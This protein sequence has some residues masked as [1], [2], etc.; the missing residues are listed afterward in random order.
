MPSSLLV[1]E[2]TGDRRDIGLMLLHPLG[3]DRRFWDACIARWSGRFTCV[4]PDLRQSTAAPDARPATL[5]EQAEGIE[6]LR[7]ALGFTRL[8]PVGCAISTMV[9]ACY[10]ARHPD[11]TAALILANATPRSS[12]QAAAMLTGRAATVRAGG[13]AAILPQAVERSFLNL[14]KDQRYDAYLAAFAAQPAETYAFACLASAAF[15]A[16][17]FLPAVRCP[18]LVVAGEHDVLLPP[19]LGRE[20]AELIP[21]AHFEIMPDAAHFAPYQRPDAFAAR[22]ADFLAGAL[23]RLAPA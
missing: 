19:A 10:A 3:A 12:P 17:P 13:M 9:A 6:D 18:S 8:I 1:H 7:A 16:G 20:V 23:P 4:A 5:V 14:P 11:R 21:G 15:D 2:V 22:V